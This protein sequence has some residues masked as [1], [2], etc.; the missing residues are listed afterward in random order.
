[1][2]TPESKARSNAMEEGHVEEKQA[3]EEE[4]EDEEEEVW[5]WSW[6]AGTDG[7]LGIGTLEDQALPQPLRFGSSSPP[8][9]LGIARIAC[10][11]AHAIALT[12]DGRVLTWGRGMRG[13]LGHGELENCVRPKPVK[14]F[15]SFTISYVSAGWNHSGFVTD[16]GRLFMCGDGSF[17]QLGNGD[18]QSHNFPV[19][20]LFFTSKHVEQIACGMRHSLALVTG[21][22]IYG[23]GSG[24]HGQIGQCLS[25][26][27]R[28]YNCPEVIQGFG[29]CKFVGLF[30]NGD[31]S[32]ALTSDG[33]LYIWG[34]GFS[35]SADDFHPRLM[36]L[37]LKISQVA[38]GW[39]HALVTTDGKVYMFGGYR[40]GFGGSAVVN[41]MQ[42][43]SAVPSTPC[44]DVDETHRLPALEKVPGLDGERVVHIATGAEH[45]ALITEKGTIMTWGWGEH[46]QLGLGGT[47]DQTCPQI[48][49]VKNRRSFA[50]APL[51]IYCGS[52]FTVVAK[53][54]V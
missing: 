12:G 23:F 6:G 34:R 31:H 46:G 38:L 11:G 50:S 17:G 3:V 39:H 43:Q 45:S 42:H 47:C 15:E 40:H 41:R 48:V 25:R 36:P 4:D 10:G 30:A 21:D 22:V 5:A 28:S 54:D 1:M 37:P 2:E 13:Q 35:G 24:R 52:G 19:E 27:Q 14:F 9:L 33:Q 20:V 8:P 51:G 26:A 53:L 16:K 44:I 29:D 32:A 18:N 7:Q 49:N